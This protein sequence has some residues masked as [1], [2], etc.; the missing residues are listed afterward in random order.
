MLK[1]SNIVYIESNQLVYH[2]LL[3]WLNLQNLNKNWYIVNMFPNIN[4][5]FFKLSLIS[6]TAYKSWLKIIK[7]G[8]MISKEQGYKIY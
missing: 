8:K 4:V 3:M 1:L 7:I 6:I 5:N 2:L